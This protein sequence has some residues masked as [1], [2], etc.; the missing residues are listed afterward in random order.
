MG[1]IVSF[2]FSLNLHDNMTYLYCCT[3]YFFLNRHYF[4]LWL[5]ILVLNKSYLILLLNA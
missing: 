5:Q 1:L 4:N 2:V 3:V